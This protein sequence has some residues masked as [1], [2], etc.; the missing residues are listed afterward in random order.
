[1]RILHGKFHQNSYDCSTHA[2]LQV[3]QTRLSFCDR[4]STTVPLV[5][6]G[7]VERELQH[8]SAE[9]PELV[10]LQA[11]QVLEEVFAEFVDAGAEVLCT[12]TDRASRLWLAQLDRG[13]KVYEL[14]RKAVWSA[15]KAAAHRA[16]VA[17]VIGP[18]P[19]S[20]KPLGPLVPEL[21][22]RSVAEQAIAL[23]DGGC[24]VLVLK[25][26]AE[27]EELLVTLETVLPIANGTPVVALKAFPEDGAVLA[28]SFPADVAQLLASRSIAAVGASGTVGPQRMRTI[29]AAMR[30]GTS[31]PIVA[32][33]DTSIPTTRGSGITYRSDEDY[34]ARSVRELAALGARIVGI[35]RGARAEHIRRIVDAL[36]T[37]T[38][39]TSDPP[40]KRPSANLS[41]PSKEP[42]P[43]RFAS[44]VRNRFVTTVEL[45]IPR[46]LD[47]Q[48]VFDGAAYLQRH[49]I[50]AVNISDG[51]RARLRVNS[52]MLSAMVSQKVG[53]EC[54]AHLACRD[55]NMVAL[56]SDLLGAWLLG[57]RNVLAISGDPTH[58]GDFP[59]ATTVGDLD[60]IGLVRA[61]RMMNSGR[62]LAGNP[63]GSAT[64]FCIACA[65]NPLADDSE[66]EFDRLAQKVAEGAEVVFTQPIFDAEMW[67]R[68]H[69][70]IRT[71][72]VRCIVGVLP[73]RS[74]RH[75]EF[76]HY[77]V[78]GMVV[79]EWARERMRRAPTP[80]HA[81]EE[82]IAIAAEFLSAIREHADGVYLMPPFKRYDVAIE[83]L[84]RVGILA[85]TLGT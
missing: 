54:I 77:E 63:L 19:Q 61:M 31:I 46:G 1:M 73:L 62:D 24:D 37:V 52:L 39:T 60:A 6:V 26:F 79:P 2:T 23:L 85:E 66:R 67:L 18:P 53:I 59:R 8:R 32:L 22:R 80:A 30:T 68:L 69:E 15:R 43:S 38:I 13:D 56:Q 84:R 35:D 47:M 40:L 3:P 33:P 75:A 36:R 44:V 71:L 34:L 41:P 81:A 21:L 12:P 49:G 74:I 5:A 16:Y 76:L 58:I 82:G 20:L 27:L 14:N 55:R 29:I 25:S 65:W 9:R 83:V 50:D 45:D 78:P 57:V 11:P 28:T 48:S 10:A 64:Q 42:E 7:S 51:A 17:G 72:P 70:R 4:L